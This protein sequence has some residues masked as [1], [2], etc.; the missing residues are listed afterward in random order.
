MRFI[1]KYSHYLIILDFLILKILV[2]RNYLTKISTLL[3]I[4]NF[5][6]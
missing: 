5:K 3:K 6:I 4:N 2:N 1:K